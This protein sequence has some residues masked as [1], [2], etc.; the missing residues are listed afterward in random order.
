MIRDEISCPLA[1]QKLYNILA[2]KN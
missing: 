2:S 1:P